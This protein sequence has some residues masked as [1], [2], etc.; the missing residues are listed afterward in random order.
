MPLQWWAISTKIIKRDVFLRGVRRSGPASA[1]REIKDVIL[2]DFE[3]DSLDFTHDDSLLRGYA[4]IQF[5]DVALKPV[6]EVVE[7]SGIGKFLSAG[8]DGY[9]IPVPR[10]QVLKFKSRV[11]K[12]QDTFKVGDTVFVTEGI[13]KGF[14]GR[15][16]KK[17]KLML[18]V[19][20]RLPNSTILRPVSIMAVEKRR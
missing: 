11:C 20:V 6:M 5:D 15:V 4:L 8:V 16:V 10:A 14:Q 9:P 1:L 18:E 13:L 12:K 17:D 3:V 19:E 2:Y 7:S